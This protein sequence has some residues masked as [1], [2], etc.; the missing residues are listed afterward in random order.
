MTPA[1]AKLIATFF[2]SGLLRPAP[3]T[4]GSLA[5]L[6]AAWLLHQIGGP[7]AL[8]GATILAYLIGVKATEPIRLAN[9]ITI[10]LRW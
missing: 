3:G 10:R 7:V 5:A 1:T 6:P 8:T 4:W 9:P 2:Y